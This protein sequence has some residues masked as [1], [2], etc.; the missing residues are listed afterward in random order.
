M[1][2]LVLTISTGQ[3]HHKTAR[4]ISDY[5]QTRGIESEVVDAYKYFNSAL[6]DFLEKGYLL[7][8][9]YAR[10]MYGSTYS[11]EER[12]DHTGKINMVDLTGKI[13]EKRFL[14]YVSKV[15]PDVIICTHVFAANL[16]S[17][18]KATY[19]SDVR[20][21]GIVT[22]FTVHPYWE[23]PELDYY[24][25]ANSLLEEQMINKGISKEKILPLGIP[26]DNKFSVSVD[27]REARQQ[28]GFEDKDTVFVMTGSM[29]YGDV[30]KYV[31][32]LDEA[33]GDFQIVT[34]CGNNKKL[35]KHID[36]FESE[37][38]IYNFGYVNNVDLVMD[39]T[40]YMVSK[41]GGL[42]TSEALAKRL[43]MILIDPIPGQEDRNFE[44]LVNNGLAI[45]VSKELSVGEAMY[46]LTSDSTRVESMRKKAS[47]LGKPYA[48]KHLADFIL[49][50]DKE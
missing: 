8:T 24:V 34:V 32:E 6:S 43:P 9:K 4:A 25:I 46:Q 38:K 33:P 31:K 23:V 45:G 22:D 10:G 19:G 18:Y 36:E 39:A 50:L 30:L 16:V 12:R 47:E 49:G 29:G 41:P 2:A 15:N 1:K 28:L 37:K 42:S 11:I 44:F 35:K 13:V 20:T 21:F 27:K 7:T 17:K 5:L 48:C 40:D 14:E 26:I 3:G